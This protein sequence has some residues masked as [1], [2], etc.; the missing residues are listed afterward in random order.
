MKRK[1]Y[2][3]DSCMGCRGCY[4]ICP[5]KAVEPK[6]EKFVINQEKC[7]GC[8]KCADYCPMGIPQPVEA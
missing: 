3:D 1:F 5:V 7:V 8:G 2:I 6:E 4:Q